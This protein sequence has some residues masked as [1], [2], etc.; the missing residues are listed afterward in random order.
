MSIGVP[1]Y[2]DTG[3]SHVQVES[4]LLVLEVIDMV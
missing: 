3:V 1:A 4:Q 2:K